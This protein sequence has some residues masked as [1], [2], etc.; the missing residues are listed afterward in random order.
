MKQRYAV[1]HKPMTFK[2]GDKVMLRLHK[3]YKLPGNPSCKY[4]HLRAGLFT[5]IRKVGSQAWD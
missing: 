1:A 4:S 3:G 2:I 5:I